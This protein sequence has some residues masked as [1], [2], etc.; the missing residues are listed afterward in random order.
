MTIRIG[1]VGGGQLGRM[2]ALAGARLDM[3]FTFLDPAEDS[4]AAPYGNHICAAYDDTVAL[5]ALASTV[6]LVTF[7]FENVPDH[8]VDQLAKK[9]PV[10]PRANSLRLSRDRLDEKNMLQSLGIETARFSDLQN[11]RELEDAAGRIG[12]PAIIKTRTLGYDGKGQK[13]VRSQ[14]D[15]VGSF[16]EMGSVPCILE[17]FVPFQREV[18]LIAVRSSTNERVFYP[19]TANVHIGGVLDTSTPI[20]EPSLQL[21]A[22]DYADRI[23][24]H[25]DYVGVLTIE[26]FVV[27]GRLVVNEIAPRVHNS[28]HWTIEG[29]YCSQFENHLR[30]I[31]GLPLGLT[32]TVAE[33]AMVNFLGAV[34]DIAKLAAIPGCNVHH[35]G[36]SFKDGR[37]VGH[38]T[39]VAKDSPTLCLLVNEVKALR[40]K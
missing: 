17:G 23:L 25:L 18:S 4:C 35:Y 6:D 14:Q 29:A 22:E 13:V 5:D 9:L 10:F 38:A 19:L 21:L 37:K 32:N 31:S 15:L 36:K 39:V 8:A 27:D 11:Q 2:M 16:D 20:A 1:V 40:I 33:C 24:A 7:E 12:Y 3:S 26:F 28:G 30:A 34:P